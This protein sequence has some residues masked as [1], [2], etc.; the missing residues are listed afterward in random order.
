MKSQQQKIQDAKAYFETDLN[1]GIKI[2]ERNGK[3]IIDTPFITIRTAGTAFGWTGLMV[4]FNANVDF[5]FYFIPLMAGYLFGAILLWMELD[6][7]NDVVLDLENNTLQVLS[8]NYVKRAL[9]RLLKWQDTF[10]FD[11]IAKITVT[12]QWAMKISDRYN[13]IELLLR[14]N[15]KVKLFYTYRRVPAVK[16]AELLKDITKLKGQGLKI[17]TR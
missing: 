3:I 4:I 14:N 16:A 6:V 11:D 5:S 15:K 13:L 1:P 12:H 9:W 8:N 7:L 17:Q 2:I 10:H